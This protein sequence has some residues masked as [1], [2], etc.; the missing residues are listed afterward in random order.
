MKTLILGANG[1]LGQLVTALAPP[2]AKVS[3]YAST[4]CDISDARSVANAIHKTGPDLIINCA[5]YTQVDKAESERDK[6][7]AVNAQGVANLVQATGPDT[8]ILHISTDFVFDG[9]ATTPYKPDSP[10][11]PPGIYG[12]SKLAGEKILLA[13]APNRSLILRTAWLYAAAGRNFLNTM[14]SLLS[15]RDELRVVND[16][17]GTPT[18]ARSLAGAIWDF[19]QQ[20]EARGIYHW[21]DGG[22]ASWHEFACAIQ[23]QALALGLL[24]REI[25]VHPIPTSEYPTPARRPAYSVLDCTTSLTLLQVQSQPWQE[26]LN[27]ELQTLFHA[28]R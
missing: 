8:R 23:K 26:A 6:A 9:K 28:R 19:A 14:L 12:A 27:M 25:P 15:S 4:V 24:S 21:T 17:V 2:H 1:Q 3:A 5:A 20:P 16:Q 10:T 13:Q 7:F 11:D 22:Q 18:S